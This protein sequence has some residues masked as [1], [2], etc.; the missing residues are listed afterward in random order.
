MIINKI[1][2]I[3]F[4]GIKNKVIEFKEDINLIY[5][6]NE[7]G[8]SRIQS[9][10]RVWLYG[11]NQKRSKDIKN[12]DRVKFMPIDGEKIRGELYISYNN[13]EYIIK[14]SFGITKKDDTSEILDAETGEIIVDINK[15]EPGK[16][17]LN[18]NYST[19]YK[20]LFINQ[21]GVAISKDKEEEIIDKA[22][23]ILNNDD[24]KISIQKS[25]ERL[26]SIKKSL[27]T[28]RKN[29]ELDILKDKLNILNQE[30]YEAY[31]LSEKSLEN[32]KRLLYLK[33]KREE[34][35]NEISNLDIYKKYLKKVKLQKEYEDITEYLK[36]K[37]ELK[38]KERYIEESISEKFGKLNIN[39]LNDIKEENSLYFSILDMCEEE[40]KELEIK[41][42][43]YFNQKNEFE[44][45]KFLEGVSNEDKNKF[46][47]AS[48]ENEI[49]KEKI[50]KFNELD[51]EIKIIHMDIKEKEN[52][53]G[54]SLNFKDIRDEVGELLNNY[55]DKLKE[56]KF[57]AE[58]YDDKESKLNKVKGIFK[59][60]I[61]FE[62]VVFVTFIVLFLV[63]KNKLFISIIFIFLILFIFYNI[64]TI[65]FK[66]NN[67]E[68][69]FTTLKLLDED[70]KNIE[71]QIF[72]YT[73]L[74]QAK[75]YEDF[76]KKL[77]IYDEFILYKERQNIKIKEKENQINLSEISKV[78]EKYINNE[79]YIEYIY[80][81]AGTNSNDLVIEMFNK[82]DE[83]N[84][85]LL[86]LK[87]EID[88]EE[89][90]I[91]K[92]KGEL[93]IR[94]KRIRDRLEEIG[95]KDIDLYELE[96]KL[97][98]IKEKVIQREE[99][100]RSL[101]NIDETYNALT[102]DKDIEAI[103]EELKD[104][105]N[106]DLNYSYSSEEEIDNQISFKSNELI[107]IEKEIKDVENIINNRFIGKRSIPEIEEE[108]EN[109]KEKVS[110]LENLLKA[111]EIAIYNMSESIREIRGNFGSILNSKVKDYF[112]DLTN[113]AYEEV[114]VSESYDMKIRQDNDLLQ[115]GMLSNGAND[116][117][118]LALR[119]SFIKMIYKDEKYPLILD[120]AFVQYDDDRLE[121]AIN[122]LYNL[123]FKQLIIFT[124][125]K[126][127]EQAFINKNISFNYIY[128]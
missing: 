82:Y 27:I 79:K 47:K 64:I 26:E 56:I 110:K 112:K 14:R 107:E 111:T 31:S 92:L 43:D 102:K 2:I 41:K 57:R 77:K 24:E 115:G 98:E 62:V 38:R 76:I 20:T 125:Q 128:L 16:Y 124:C 74:I 60:L 21:L 90:S 34:T 126:R 25:L 67:L 9:F 78:K 22:S 123:R 28:A 55:E 101:K 1:N 95:L 35:R 51:K 11:M 23:N 99:I 84:K 63:V 39:L 5:G 49:L 70:I 68:K 89:K 75:S 96:E 80:D 114:L 18:V 40:E 73:K 83:F 37:E 29:G 42:D 119:L 13:R 61:G 66:I 19:F 120:D 91:L 7:K 97:L 85:N 69:E 93:K 127:E 32:E 50:Q 100:L 30:K 53:I 118:Y 17:F 10:I 104:I 113:N 72:K 81:L 109:T 4:A 52:F 46:I 44:N 108:I 105:I 116:Q 58:S 88:K 122:L 87:V 15:D 59:Y 103:K 12:N 45:L 3:S 117:L 94:E 33:E 86:S 48:M 54:A 65:K 8:K 106:Q 36:K 6:E 121:N 71:K